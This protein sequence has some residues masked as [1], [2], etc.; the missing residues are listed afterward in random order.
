MNINCS[1]TL[2]SILGDAGKTQKYDMCYGDLDESSINLGLTY[3]DPSC[4]S[5]LFKFDQTFVCIRRHQ[6]FQKCMLSLL[7]SSFRGLFQFLLQQYLDNR[8][9]HLLE[10]KWS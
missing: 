7:Q 10:S 4:R 5:E 6:K 3:F 2:H 9:S 1:K 8:I